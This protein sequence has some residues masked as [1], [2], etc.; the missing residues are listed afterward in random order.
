MNP[1]QKFGIATASFLLAAGTD[2]ACI[3]TIPATTPTARFIVNGD[4]T[5]I[6]TR[7][8]LMWMRCSLG[9]AW[10]GTTC[11]GTAAQYV[12]ADALAQ[13]QSSSYAGHS[14]WRV[15]NVKELVS[16]V[17]R[18]C[19]YPAI[20]TDLF[21][22]TATWKYWTS[23][24]SVAGPGSWAQLVEFSQGTD[25]ADDKSSADSLWHYHV[26]LVRTAR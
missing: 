13:A 1:I 8:G 12:W 9:Q 7:T 2:A 14:D 22:A 10:T 16:I 3:S 19:A 5:V 15:P 18:R 26:R 4:G 23:T 25:P 11:T 20:N 21:P 6:D 24:P 17:E